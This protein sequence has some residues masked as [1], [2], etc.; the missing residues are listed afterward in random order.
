MKAALFFLALIFTGFVFSQTVLKI[1]TFDKMSQVPVTYASVSV[2]ADSVRLNKVYTNTQGYA[3]VNITEKKDLLIRCEQAAYT[4][5]EKEMTAK[6]L[7]RDTIKVT[8][9]MLFQKASNIEEV[10][11]YPVGVPR[12]IFESDRVSVDDFEILPDDRYVLL[13]YAKNKKKGTELYLYD[14]DKVQSKI[15]VGDNE[16]GQEL[17]RDYRGNPHLVTDK[18]VYGITARGNEVFIGGVEKNYFMN[19]IAPIVDTS[20]SKFYFSNYNPDFPAFDYFTY[21]LIDSSY[22]KIAQVEDELMMELYRSEYKWVDV[23]TKLWAKDMENE[24]GID[25]EIWVGASYFTQ[26][27]YYKELYA[28][29]FKRN[30]TLFLFDHYKNLMF[31]FNETGD[32]MDSVPIFYHLQPK[33]TGWKKLLLQDQTTGQVYVVY[34]KVGQ[35]YLQR[36]DL[37][38]GETKET[39]PLHYKYPEKIM[40]RSNKVYYTYREFE[41]AQK[42]YLWTEKMPVDFPKVKV[43]DG[44]PLTTN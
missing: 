18:N 39:I 16:M 20:V 15:P 14:G 2:F 24:T 41:T 28:P 25:A 27:I 17:I 23:R 33:Q 36:L 34:E 4:D 26:S 5:E 13:T 1:Y 42:K 21:D 29:L 12:K 11:I 37:A 30:D 35:Y 40:V 10:I 3:Y 6:S 9:Y 38:T 31:R 19:Y 32:V 8:I 7:N 43:L 44:D 22:R